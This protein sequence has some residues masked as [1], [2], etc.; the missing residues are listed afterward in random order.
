MRENYQKINEGE[1]AAAESSREESAGVQIAAESGWEER[2]DE[3]VAAEGRDATGNSQ[4]IVGD[5]GEKRRE[6][7]TAVQESNRAVSEKRFG[8]GKYGWIFL[9]GTLLYVCIVVP[10]ILWHGGIFFYYG[11]YNVQQVPFYILA[12]R[13]VREGNFFWN[14]GVDLGSN[15]GGSFAFYLW[16]SPFFWLTIPFPE[17]WLPYMMPFLM[18]LKFGTATA[19]AFAWIRTQTKTD[20]AALLGALLY[21]FSGFQACNIVFQHFHEVT[22]FFPLYLLVFDR[23]VREKKRIGFTLMTAFMAIL[24]YYFFVGEV[25]FLFLYYMVR[26]AVRQSLRETLRQIAGLL[27]FGVWGLA[28]AA[29]FLVQSVTGLFGNSR[30]SNWISGYDIVAYPDSTTPLAI[31]K[32]LFMVPDL[33]AK[34]TLFSSDEIKNSSMA[35]YLPAL[36]LTGVIAY[37]LTHRKDWKKT[38]LS[39]LAVMAFVPV[40]NSL[41]SA[42]NAAYYARWYYLPILLMAAVSAQAMEEG[43]RKA[44]RTGAIATFTATGLL[45]L[46]ACLPVLQDDGTMEWF[47]LPENPKLLVT[48]IAATAATLPVLFY[49]IFLYRPKRNRS[50]A[51]GRSV[52][53]IALCAVFCTAAVLSNGNRL[54]AKTGGVKWR[55]QMLTDRPELSDTETFSRVETDSTSTNYEMVWGYATIHCFQS[56]VNPSIF[57]F[58]TGIGMN[59]TVES[60]LPFSR[61]G[62]R[63]ILSVRYYLENDLVSSDNSYTDQGGLPGYEVSGESGGYHIYENT[64]FIPMG[65]TF[66]SYM[67]QENYDQVEKGEVADRLLV[68]NLILSEEDAQKYGYLMEEDTGTEP[69]LMEEETFFAYCDERAESACSEFAFDNSGFTAR[70]QLG[71]ENLVFF[72]VPYDE[73]W[74]ARVDGEEAEI[75]RADYGLMAVYVPEGEH[76]IEFTYVPYGFG[77]GCAVSAAAAVLIALYAAGRA[78]GRRK[79]NSA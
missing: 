41:F 7:K 23:F 14:A 57:D 15:M 37:F 54:I 56:T 65:F 79:K 12:H 43:D 16:G 52:V 69:G 5:L 77:A 53:L 8:R 70:T 20:M 78:A 29:F 44:L 60:T 71:E 55:Q 58:Y 4:T 24:N 26:Y 6:P 66:R 59:R 76:K 36:A 1:G 34:G 48:E 13:A 75:V 35:A 63:A 72:S 46:C 3:Q 27:V 47:S 73:G 51:T 21:A 33:I 74:S 32:S 40:L 30:L 67:T 19:T 9:L 50:R 68:K 10:F 61:I 45:I 39:V 11:D 38:L 42:L 17:A 22:A 25:V 18:A 2:T 62:A 64:H 49:L 31:L 28:L